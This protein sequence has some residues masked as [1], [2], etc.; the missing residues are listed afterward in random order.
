MLKKLV[1]E[2]GAEILGE[3]DGI[4]CFRDRESGRVLRLYA[5]SLKTADDVALALKAAAREPVVAA[6]VVPLP[7]LM[8]HRKGDSKRLRERS[9]RGR[10][11]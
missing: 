11:C 4:V 1:E 2:A 3:S 7:T 5:R 10:H 9:R 8:G 6:S